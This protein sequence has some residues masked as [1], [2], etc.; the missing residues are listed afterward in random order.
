MGERLQ[1]VVQVS[2]RRRRRRPS[3]LIF[4]GV[5]ALAGAIGWLWVSI[6]APLFDD[7]DD[8]V[9][10]QSKYRKILRE[11]VHGQQEGGQPV[12]DLPPWP[13]KMLDAQVKVLACGEKQVVVYSLLEAA[14]WR[15][16]AIGNSIQMFQNVDV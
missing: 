13:P 1:P 15:Q 8:W 11:V 9:N 5:L 3:L 12:P 4:I 7:P 10:R 14:C 6:F 16:Q 2:S